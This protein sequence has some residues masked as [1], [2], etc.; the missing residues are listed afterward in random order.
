MTD[1]DINVQEDSLLL[2][3]AFLDKVPIVLL[4]NVN[5]II[6]NFLTLISKLRSESNPSR[7]LS[8]NLGSK[9]TSIRWRIKVLKRLLQILEIILS[10]RPETKEQK[11]PITLNAADVGI[12][13]PIYKKWKVGYSYIFDNSSENNNNLLQYA[14]AI[15]PLLYETWAEVAPINKNN[16]GNGI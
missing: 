13:I 1:I 2:I 9:L 10:S 7:T 4:S 12:Y 15:I 11:R 8:I 3:D 6:S 16:I 14:D 5:K